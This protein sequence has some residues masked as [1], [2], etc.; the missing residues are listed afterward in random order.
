MHYYNALKE[1]ENLRKLYANIVILLACISPQCFVFFGLVI[2]QDLSE[3]VF[4]SCPPNQTTT[5]PS[6]FYP[7]SPFISLS[8]GL[9]PPSGKP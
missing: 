5:L 6:R 9:C 4:L 7:P 2:L 8:A 1:Q 3:P